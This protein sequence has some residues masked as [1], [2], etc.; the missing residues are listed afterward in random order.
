MSVGTNDGD[1]DADED[2]GEDVEGDDDD[3]GEENDGM[4]GFGTLDER[5]YSAMRQLKRKCEEA[6]IDCDVLPNLVPK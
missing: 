1:D 2:D 6:N 5:V 3:K 4:I